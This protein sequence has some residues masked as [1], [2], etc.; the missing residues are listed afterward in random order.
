MTPICNQ[1]A[2]AESVCRL[3]VGYAGED[4]LL[5]V[6]RR[7]EDTREAVQLAADASH[8]VQRAQLDCVNRMFFSG[9]LISPSS[10]QKVP[11]RVIPVKVVSIGL[12]L[13]V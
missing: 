8:V 2:V 4:E 12:I 7:A 6:Q 3:E 9:Y 5:K 13:F 1:F 11:S 10:T